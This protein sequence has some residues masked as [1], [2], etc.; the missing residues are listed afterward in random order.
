M[1]FV[2]F[3]IVTLI[4]FGGFLALGTW[5]V[6]RLHWKLAL[7]ARVN[8]RVH[9]TPVPAPGPSEWADVN[10]KNS[11]YR[12]VY[13]TGRFLNDKETYVYATTEKGLGF[14]V[15]TPLKR[16]DGTIVLVNRGFVPEDRK[17]PSTREAGEIKGPVKVTGLIRISEPGGRWLRSNKPKQDRWYSRDVAAIAAKRGLSNVAPYFIDADA[18]PNPG[19]LPVGGLTRIHFR[20]EHLVY[21]ITWYVLALLTAIGFLYVARTEWLARRRWANKS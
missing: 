12:H 5:Q 11:E 18:T 16:P 6:Q 4:F 2:L 10:T 8:D 9:A 7:I 20:N 21:A 3:G 14:W 1:K 17:A 13:L 15:I 19:G